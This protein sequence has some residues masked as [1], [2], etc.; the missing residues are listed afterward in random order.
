MTGL[1]EGPYT[2]TVDDSTGVLSYGTTLTDTE[3]Y[4]STSVVNFILSGTGDILSHPASVDFGQ[5]REGEVAFDDL[6]E[7]DLVFVSAATAKSLA[8]KLLT[9]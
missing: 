9:F 1:R 6:L 4:A 5:F 2:V 3:G 7:A 8:P